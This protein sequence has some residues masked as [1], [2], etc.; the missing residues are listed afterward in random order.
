MEIHPVVCELYPCLKMHPDPSPKGYHFLHPFTSF[1]S[2]INNNTN[3]GCFAPQRVCRSHVWFQVI[4]YEHFVHPDPWFFMVLLRLTWTSVHCTYI[5][6]LC[7]FVWWQKGPLC[8]WMIACERTL[9]SDEFGMRTGCEGRAQSNEPETLK[10]NYWWDKLVFRNLHLTPN[11]N[12]RTWTGLYMNGSF[13]Y[14][15]NPP[16]PCIE[17]LPNLRPR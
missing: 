3:T 4:T 5:K 10:S 9:I 16:Y 1:S 11:W 12:E 14:I 7:M 13:F 2:F 8:I 15:D 17:G 6:P